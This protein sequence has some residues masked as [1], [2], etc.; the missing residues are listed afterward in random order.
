[1]ALPNRQVDLRH[2]II[3]GTEVAKSRK[4]VLTL[5]GP[6]LPKH[7]HLT[8]LAERFRRLFA[9]VELDA[10]EA[11]FSEA[12]VSSRPEPVKVSKMCRPRRG[13]VIAPKASQRV[14]GF[15]SFEAVLEPEIEVEEPPVSWKQ[16]CKR[17]ECEGRRP[18]S[19]N[20]LRRHVPSLAVTA[21]EIS[22]IDTERHI[23]SAAISADEDIP[24][25]QAQENHR[26]RSDC[27]S[28]KLFSRNRAW[29][30]V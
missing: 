19:R 17:P 23:P 29:R 30:R 10:K 2:L 9:K 24:A 22:E 5:P 11:C 16:N 18:S 15:E 28:S 20:P 27:E 4:G 21:A 8:G 14:V 7:L 25:D 6:A 26:Q 13:L 3:G 1:M 12:V